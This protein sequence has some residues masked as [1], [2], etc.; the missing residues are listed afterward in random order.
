[1]P[2]A[3]AVLASSWLAIHQA[4]PPTLALLVLLCCCCCGEGWQSTNPLELLEFV[5]FLTCVA[6]MFPKPG[7]GTRTFYLVLSASA[8]RPSTCEETYMHH[9]FGVLC[10]VGD[11]PIQSVNLALNT[12]SHKPFGSPWAMLATCRCCGPDLMSAAC[13]QW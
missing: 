9:F 10:Y 7:L 13:G 6:A 2:L 11:L 8:S 12:H 1:M 3:L 5:L 4:L